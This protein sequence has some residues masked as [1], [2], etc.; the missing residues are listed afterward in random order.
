MAQKRERLNGMETALQNKRFSQ[1]IRTAV[2]TAYA[3]AV[4][5]W[6]KAGFSKRLL[7]EAETGGTSTFQPE[8]VRK[9]SPQFQSRPGCC[10][11]AR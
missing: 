1:E 11:T 8:T 10:N 4:A 3:G 5:A 6:K 9:A 7:A 2:Y